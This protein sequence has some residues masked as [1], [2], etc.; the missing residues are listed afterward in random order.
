VTLGVLGAATAG[1]IVA[2]PGSADAGD[3]FRFMDANQAC[4]IGSGGRYPTAA[5]SRFEDGGLWCENNAE[6]VSPVP[7]SVNY[8]D[9]CRAQWQDPSLWAEVNDA[10]MRRIPLVTCHKP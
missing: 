8:S 6:A 9:V 10:R 4:Q 2:A 1:L 5:G 7:V 3:A